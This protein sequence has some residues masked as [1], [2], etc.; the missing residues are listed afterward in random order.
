MQMQLSFLKNIVSATP[1]QDVLFSLV[2]SSVFVPLCATCF[3]TRASMV[4]KAKELRPVM[5]RIPEELCRRLGREAERNM[6]SMNAEMVHRLRQ[7]F[8]IRDE[9]KA[10]A[11]AVIEQ[12][13]A[14]GVREWLT[15]RSGAKV[16]DAPTTGRNLPPDVVRPPV[17]GMEST[18]KPKTEDD[19]E[20]Q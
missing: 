17:G 2:K 5:T 14:V 16:G 9:S 20:G 1:C 6:R 15:Q 12:F 4:R 8:R 3:T 13:S 10:I 19:G 7:S 18:A 11:T